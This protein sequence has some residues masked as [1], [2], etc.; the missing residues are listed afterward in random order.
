MVALFTSASSVNSQGTPFTFTTVPF[1]SFTVSISIPLPPTFASTHLLLHQERLS[2]QRLS[3]ATRY[4]LVTKYPLASF[5]IF[6]RENQLVRVSLRKLD[7][8]YPI[9]RTRE[10]VRCVEEVWRISSLKAWFKSLRR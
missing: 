9:Q 6:P 2:H 4:T 1:G 5:F 10:E 7:T 8:A 3:L